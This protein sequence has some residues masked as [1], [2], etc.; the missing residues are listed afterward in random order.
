MT[1]EQFEYWMTEVRPALIAMRERQEI[2]LRES[3]LQMIRRSVR[4]VDTEET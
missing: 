2:R 1:P 3:A 4:P